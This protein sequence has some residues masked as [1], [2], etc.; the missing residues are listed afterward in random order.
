[1]SAI[2][3]RLDGSLV[4]IRNARTSVRPALARSLLAVCATLI[5][6][7]APAF[8]AAEEGRRIDVVQI[9]GN[10]RVDSQAIRI[11]IKTRPGDRLEMSKVDADVRAIFAMGFFE[12]VAAE[13]DEDG[14]QTTL[15]F[16]VEER[17]IITDI[18]IE[19]NDELDEDELETALA[20]RP[21]TIYDPEKVRRGVEAAK[22]LYEEKGYLDVD[23]ESRVEEKGP[24][25]VRLVYEIDQGAEISI[26]EI[27]FEGN[28]NFSD[29]ELRGVMQTKESWFLSF[30]LGSGT[31]NRDELK[32]DVERL[33]AFYYDNGYVNVKI[34]TPVVKREGDELQVAVRIE[35]GEPFDFGD[36]SFAGDYQAPGV[37]DASLKEQVGAKE[38]DVF[39]ASLLRED[40]DTLSD[41]YGDLGYAFANVEPE[42][43]IRPE[44]K[45]V[46]VNYRVSKG[47][48]VTIGEIEITGNTKTRDKVVRREMRIHEKEQFSATK[49]RRSRDAL[50]RLGFFSEVNVTTRKASNPDEINVLV[51]LKEGS[52]GAFSAGA[53]FSSGDEFLFNVRVSE[54]NLFGYGIR[55]VANADIGTIRNN[56]FL[57]ATDPY[58]LDTQILGSVTL[59][60]ADLEFNDFTRSSTG[61]SLRALY[62]L[63]ALGLDAIGPVSLED[64]RVGVEY[65]LERARISDVAFDAP[66]SIFTE[67][68]TSTISSLS[69]NFLRNTLNHAFDPTDGSFQEV[70]VEFAG[71]GGDTK[72][73][74]FEARG[75]WFVPVYRI[76]GFG[77]LVYS[78]GGTIAYGKGEEGLSGA[79]I[80]LVQRYF[81]G[82]I[83]T[84]RG[85]ET[86]T[87]GPREN[88][89]NSQGE[90]INNQAVGG[91]NELILQNE[92][93]FPIVQQLGLRGVAFFDLG[94]AWFQKDG[95]DIGDL[96]YSVGGGVRW[97]SPFGPLR[98]ELGVPLNRKGD[99]DDQLFQFSFGAP[100]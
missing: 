18:D 86:R 84:V 100:L 97:L 8:A 56:I 57:S 27:V 78:S 94:N 37:E 68:G 6:A 99:E 2:A 35:E 7:L 17:P 69:P 10:S 65:R 89:F 32:T 28:E 82:G 95:I 51:D 79:E 75:R 20:V 1:M 12:N 5:A 50:R 33:T 52:T 59:F 43:L 29:R 83:N 92:L 24:G 4:G 36:V 21:R 60:T 15:T 22:R 76:P 44:D 16:R 66:P 19:G 46:D 40:V 87:L 11:H 70:S 54:N 49:L 42:T 53:G 13:L 14:G 26:G 61:I 81:P 45:R 90:I 74:L 63:E 48:P 9:T 73:V 64:T 71:V 55:V 30:L 58:F 85:F 96:R 31:L 41:Y 93:I 47:N 38:G 77:P 39:R 72:F 98:L 67:S 62:P 25:E 80:P 88:T 3:S 34:D 91:T 23:V